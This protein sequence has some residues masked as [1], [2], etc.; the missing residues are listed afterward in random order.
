MSSEWGERSGSSRVPPSAASSTLIVSLMLY[1][2]DCLGLN[3][4]L[5]SLVWNKPGEK[6]T[7]IFE[8]CLQAVYPSSQTW[9]SSPRDRCKPSLKELSKIGSVSCCEVTALF[10]NVS[11]EQGD[12]FNVLLF[13]VKH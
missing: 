5:T 1:I 7:E 6:R 8:I 4:A 13:L 11:M 3:Q 12:S 9:R 2:G 10:V